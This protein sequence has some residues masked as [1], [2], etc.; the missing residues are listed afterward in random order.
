MQV[1]AY[2]SAGAR[3]GAARMTETG[4]DCRKVLQ[5]ALDSVVLQSETKRTLESNLT[6]I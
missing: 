1:G 3:A 5:L 6:A 2:M 4:R